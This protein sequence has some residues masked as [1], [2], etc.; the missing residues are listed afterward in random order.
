MLSSISATRG[1]FLASD[2]AREVRRNRQHAVDA[3]VAQIVERLPLVGV[4]DDVEGPRA[5]RRRRRASSRTLH[6]RHAVIL[7][8]DGQLQVL[9]VAAEGVAEHDELHERKDH[10]HDDQHRAAAEAPQLAFDD[11]PAFDACAH[12]IAAS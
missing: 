10:R 5:G 2:A 3:A 1:S 7:I 6:R 12:L 9:D 8:D 11:G 4:V